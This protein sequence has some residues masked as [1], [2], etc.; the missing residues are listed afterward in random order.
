MPIDAA[1]RQPDLIGEGGRL[2]VGPVVLE[3]EEKNMPMK[4]PAVRN[5]YHRPRKV[6]TAACVIDVKAP[7]A[8]GKRVDEDTG[9][10]KRFSPA[11]PS[12]C[13]SPRRSA[14]S[15]PCSTA[16]LRPTSWPP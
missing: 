7:R 6:T 9:E 12:W 11:I 15:C 1:L 5:G 13:R 10:R 2:V 16:C 3:A 14:K 8:D 4:K